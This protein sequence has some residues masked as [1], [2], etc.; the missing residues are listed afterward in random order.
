V[1]DRDLVPDAAGANPN[2]PNGT[3]LSPW[4]VTRVL[5]EFLRQL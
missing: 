5:L 2:R 3:S 1:G 4:V